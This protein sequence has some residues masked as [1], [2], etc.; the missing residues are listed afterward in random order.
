[1]M[2]HHDIDAVVK[3][4]RSAIPQVE[5]VQLQVSH[6]GA[7]DDGLWWFRL[8]AVAR[9]IQ[10]ESSTYNCPFFMEHSDMK[11]SSEAVIAHTVEQAATFVVSYLRSIS[12]ADCD[13]FSQKELP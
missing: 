6:P 7:D 13:H 1:M 9:D 4:V 2:E 5:V 10:I 8:P 3:V 12:D 11:S